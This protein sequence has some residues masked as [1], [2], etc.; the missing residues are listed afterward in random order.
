MPISTPHSLYEKLRQI[1]TNLP[2][3]AVSLDLHIEVN[4]LPTM[5]VVQ[6][7]REGAAEPASPPHF[8]LF[9]VLPVEEFDLLMEAAGVTAPARTGIQFPISVATE[10]AL[11]IVS[12]GDAGSTDHPTAVVCMTARARDEATRDFCRIAGD[13]RP[14]NTMRELMQAESRPG[15][16]NMVAFPSGRWVQWD[17]RHIRAAP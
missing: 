14:E 10:D 3:Q 4:E 8:E 15:G 1:I 7:P 13:P 2:E 12:T 5:L 9:K 16:A 6:L 11:W 17:R